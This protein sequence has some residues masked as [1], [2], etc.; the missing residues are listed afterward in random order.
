MNEWVNK[1]NSSISIVSIFRTPKICNR[2]SFMFLIFFHTFTYPSLPVIP[3]E[4]PFLDPQI[5][6]EAKGL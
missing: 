3:C 4:D 2:F 5:L 6:P 1:K